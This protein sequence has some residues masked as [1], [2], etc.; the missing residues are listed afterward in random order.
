[1]V[2]RRRL[3]LGLAAAACVPAARAQTGRTAAASRPVTVAQFV[4]TSAQQQDVSKDFLIGSRAAWQEINVK[5]GLHGRPVRHASIEVDGSA[6]GVQSA[7]AAVRENPGCI[8]LSGTAGDPLATAML[9]A[10]RSESIPIAHVAPWLQNSGIEVDDRTF[11]IFAARQEQIGHA[12][13]SL[14]ALGVQDIGAVHASEREYRE[15]HEDLQRTAVEFKLRLHTFR[16][17]GELHRLGQKLSAETP[18]ILLFIG[19]TPELVQFTQGLE[20]QTRQRFVVALAD[21]NLQ[22]LVQMGAGRN[23]PVI[24]TQPVPMVNSN[25]PVVRAYRDALGRFFDEPPTPLGLAGYIA[26]RY[27]FEVLSE[28][29]GA[30]TRQSALAAFQ[31]RT[32]LDVGGFRVA[33]DPRRRGGAYVTQSMLTTD[34][35]VVG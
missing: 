30:L 11:P 31:R 8:A 5:G 4:D 21:I 25:F 16:A 20:K 17:E 29:G 19:G 10:L 9:R 27:T 33:Y 13:K 35:R 32:T 1:M 15:Y 26:A 24:A 18:A 23:T 28:G 3:V 7:L 12:L 34:G 6:A 22:T 2:V 14:S